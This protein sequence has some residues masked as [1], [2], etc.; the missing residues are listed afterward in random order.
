MTLRIHALL[1][2]LALSLALLAACGSSSAPVAEA[3]A[4]E[5]PAAEAAAKEAPAE[6]PAATEAPATEAPAEEPAAT[7]APAAEAPA[8]EAPAAAG[9]RT[10]AIVPEQSTASYLVDEAFLGQNIDWVKTEG[11]TSAV[12]GNITL[13]IDGATVQPGDNEITVDLRTLT[14]DQRRRDNAIKTRWLESEKYPYAVFKATEVSDFP[15]DAALGQ[16]VSFKLAG[17]MTIR[18]ITQPLTFNVTA[19]I[20]GD[21]LSGSAQT[22]LLMKDFGFDPPDI[23]GMLKVTDGVTVTVNFA[24]A[25]Q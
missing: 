12:T 25:E 3:P 18:E 16:D 2:A 22:V 19:K 21:T 11:K 14:S 24:A 5:A 17:D 8:T 6:E 23:A 1:P 20:D 15:A 7:E 9:A 10:F 4:T 13:N